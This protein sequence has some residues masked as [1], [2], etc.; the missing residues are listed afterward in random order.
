MG[1]LPFERAT[2]ER[3]V[4]QA[5]KPSEK[6][7]AKPEERP[8]QTLLHY[9]IINLDKPAGP[10]SHQ[11]SSYVQKILKIKKAGHSGTLDP[12]VTGI[13]PVALD[14]GT[15]VVQ[16]LL[17]A[18]KEYVCLMK[19]H[20]EKTREEVEAALK[21]FTGRI[22]QLPPVKSAVKRQWRYRNVY[23]N[24]LIEHDGADVLFRTGCQAGTYIRKLV[25]DLGQWLGC[26]AHM[27][28]LRRTKAGPFKEDD[29]LVTLHDLKDAYVFWKEEG[30]E[31]HLR[32][33]IQPL[34]RAVS[35]LP[36]VVVLDT[37][38]DTICHGATLKV[39]GISAVTA[40]IQRGEPVAVMTLKGELVAVGEAEMTSKDMV[41]KTSGV[42]VK[43]TQVFMQPGTY[44]K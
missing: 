14:K 24:E 41:A 16:S 22:K 18:G 40:G 33:A 32:K 23:Y 38:V 37:T 44:K 1:Q 26:G 27:A 42:A 5:A 43:S 36:D 13:L 3:L 29:T 28:E 21:E 7:G 2:K 20:Q 15:R 10:S 39:R 31:T 19:L 30:D 8:I 35:H 6:Y 12:G 25:H 4:R 11:V 9:G 17:T 34:E